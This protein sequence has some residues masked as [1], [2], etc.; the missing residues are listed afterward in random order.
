M[1]RSGGKGKEWEGWEK[2]I[3]LQKEKNIPPINKKIKQE[4]NIVP[5][6]GENFSRSGAE[7]LINVIRIFLIVEKIII[8]G[9]GWNGTKENKKNPPH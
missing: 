5:N 9:M 4:K 6:I 1:K 7:I 2:I 3:L 8:N